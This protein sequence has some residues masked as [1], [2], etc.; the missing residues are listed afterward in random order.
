MLSDIATGVPGVSLRA[1][2]CSTP[3]RMARS[4]P[5]LQS[6]SAMAIESSISAAKRTVVVMSDCSVEHDS[7]A[8]HFPGGATAV[9]SAR[10]RAGRLPARM[11][12]GVTTFPTSGSSSRSRL[13]IVISH[14]IQFHAPLYTWLARDGRFDLRVFFM[15]DRGARPYYDAFARKMVQF[16]NPILEG[17]DHVFLSRGEPKGKWARKTELLRWSLRRELAKWHPEAVYFHG[18]DNPAFWP[19]VL[20]C[21]RN[22][23]AV[24]FRGENE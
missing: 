3:T 24:L 9:P 17:Y 7:F 2:S 22:G 5:R 20:W 13:A 21:R 1:G 12:L 4:H 19:A 6:T 23:V 8:G 10:R 15:T 18:Y 14:P 11:R 16:D